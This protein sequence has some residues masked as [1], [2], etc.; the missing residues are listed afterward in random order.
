MVLAQ[1]HQAASRWATS[2]QRSC[3]QSSDVA[4]VLATHSLLFVI[5]RVALG[6]AVLAQMASGRIG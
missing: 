5:Y 1:E 6:S 3:L 2:R 4:Q